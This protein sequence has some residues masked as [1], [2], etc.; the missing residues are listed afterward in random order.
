MTK[1]A[2]RPEFVICDWGFFRHLAL[3]IR[4]SWLWALH[5]KA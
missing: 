1:V 4:H 3:V 2:R 5:A